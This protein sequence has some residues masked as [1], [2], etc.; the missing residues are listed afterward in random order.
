LDFVAPDLLELWPWAGKPISLRGPW[1]KSPLKETMETTCLSLGLCDQ[2]VRDS[3]SSL[4]PFSLDLCAV[5]GWEEVAKRTWESHVGSTVC[6]AM[7]CWA[8]NFGVVAFG[9]RCQRQG[10]RGAHWPVLSPYSAWGRKCG[11]SKKSGGKAER[12]SLRCSLAG[13]GLPACGD[14]QTFPDERGLWRWGGW[15]DKSFWAGCCPHPLQ[16]SLVRTGARKGP[17]GTGSLGSQ[18]SMRRL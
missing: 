5:V 3:I 10:G 12:E 1:K 4:C 13:Q 16:D 8:G 11:K 9:F 15:A 6:E 18:F 2:R 14:I 7:G 17:K